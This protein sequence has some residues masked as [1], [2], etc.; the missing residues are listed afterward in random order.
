MGG[1]FIVLAVLICIFVVPFILSNYL[2][3]SRRVPDSGFGMG[4][5]L[6]SILAAGTPCSSRK[7]SPPQ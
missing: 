5:I 7:S 4:V 1:W 2:A 6:S 3:K